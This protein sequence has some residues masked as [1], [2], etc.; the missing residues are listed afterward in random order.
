M[1]KAYCG[2]YEGRLNGPDTKFIAR[3]YTSDEPLKLLKEE[4]EKSCDFEFRDLSYSTTYTVEVC[5]IQIFG[6]TK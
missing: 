6:H 1:I 5:I 3:L 2:H 4:T